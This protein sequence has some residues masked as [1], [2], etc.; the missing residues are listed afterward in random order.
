MLRDTTI[1]TSLNIVF[2]RT[3]L[4]LNSLQFVLHMVKYQINRWTPCVCVLLGSSL[5]V[6]PDRSQ[7]R[8]NSGLVSAGTYKI[9]GDAWH[10]AHVPRA[11]V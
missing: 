2:A 5:R 4:T 1:L 7:I 6:T 9:D 10:V 8:L 3:M 11:F